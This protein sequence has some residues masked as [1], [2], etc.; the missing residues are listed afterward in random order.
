[1][2]KRPTNI[3]LLLSRE[4]VVKKENTESPRLSPKEY[5]KILDNVQLDIISL[6]SCSAKVN[7][8]KFGKQMKSTIKDKVS[9]NLLDENEVIFIQHYDFISTK[10]NQKE[11]ALKISCSFSAKFSSVEPLSDDFLE[12]FSKVNIHVNTWPYFREFV[13]S[14]TQRMSLP[15]VTLPLLKRG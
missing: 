12:I 1:M 4:S 7:Q 3:K 11:F 14:I 10:T 13:Q 9:Y 5:R 8:D 6:D 15:P 2:V